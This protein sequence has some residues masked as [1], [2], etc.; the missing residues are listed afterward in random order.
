[1][2]SSILKYKQKKSTKVNV[3]GSKFIPNTST[4]QL[5]LTNFYL[6]FEMVGVQIKFGIW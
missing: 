6:H 5:M 4:Y 3:F 1:M 2:L